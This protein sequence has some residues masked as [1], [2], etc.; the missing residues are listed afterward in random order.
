MDELCDAMDGST[1][2]ETGQLWINKCNLYQICIPNNLSYGTLWIK[3]NTLNEY[4]EL[5]I[6]PYLTRLVVSS[7]HLYANL[8]FNPINNL[9]NLR[10]L[11]LS[12]TNPGSG[13]CGLLSKLSFTNFPNLEYLNLSNNNLNDLAGSGI[14]SLKKLETLD[15]SGN[16]PDIL[17]GPEIYIKS[18]THLD[19][20]TCYAHFNYIPANFENLVNLTQL[21][22]YNNSVSFDLNLLFIALP[23]LYE[24]NP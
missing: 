1:L 10:H 14:S 8:N 11:D 23:N 4:V 15:V 18:L 7:N 5:Y 20:S 17:Y 2:E 3:P 21:D 13:V 24:L 19:I 22:M 6:N 9:V 16:N 12:D